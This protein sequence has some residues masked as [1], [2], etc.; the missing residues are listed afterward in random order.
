[1]AG[2]LHN[3]DWSLVVS[4]GELDK[5]WFETTHKRPMEWKLCAQRD[6]WKRGVVDTQGVWLYP[7]GIRINQS[8]TDLQWVQVVLPPCGLNYLVRG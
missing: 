1:M 3:V 8:V 2:A 5:L 7:K 6:L 4:L